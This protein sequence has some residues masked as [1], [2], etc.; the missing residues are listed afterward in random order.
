MTTTNSPVVKE[1][2]RGGLVRINE[3]NHTIDVG[4]LPTEQDMAR[5]AAAGVSATARV[6]EIFE[7][8]GTDGRVPARQLN[9]EGAPSGIGR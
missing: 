4:Q 7:G 2:R 1:A 6:L 5:S 3:L 8:V 9:L